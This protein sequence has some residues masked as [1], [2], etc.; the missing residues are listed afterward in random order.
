MYGG[1]S[2]VWAITGLLH[3]ADYDQWPEEHPMRIV[4][5]LF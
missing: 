4:D 5:W 1:D 2:Q 3:D